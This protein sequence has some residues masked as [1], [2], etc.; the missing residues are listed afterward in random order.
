MQHTYLAYDNIHRQTAQLLHVC[1]N[2]DLS[3]LDKDCMAYASSNTD[4][5]SFCF[6]APK[7]QPIQG[8]NPQT[9][10]M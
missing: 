10:H 1:N 2:R 7:G 4:I 9:W 3:V 8:E 6:P 5:S